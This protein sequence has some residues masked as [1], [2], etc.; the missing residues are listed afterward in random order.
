[1]VIQFFIRRDPDKENLPYLEMRFLDKDH[2]IHSPAVVFRSITEVDANFFKTLPDET[3]IQFID[4]D[5]T[6]VYHLPLDMTR[7][8]IRTLASFKK[9]DERVCFDFAYSLEHGVYEERKPARATR[10]PDKEDPRY[11]CNE[12]TLSPGSIVALYGHH[13]GGPGH[14]AVYIGGGYYLNPYNPSKMTITPRSYF[15]T[16]FKGCFVARDRQR[17]IDV[18]ESLIDAASED[19][20]YQQQLLMAAAISF[21][22][23]TVPLS[24]FTGKSLLRFGQFFYPERRTFPQP[25]LNA[26][27]SPD[28][29]K[30]GAKVGAGEFFYLVTEEGQL[31]L[32]KKRS[33]VTLAEI[34]GGRSLVSA[35]EVTIEQGR[36]RNLLVSPELNFSNEEKSRRVAQHVFKRF[37]VDERNFFDHPLV[38]KSRQGAYL[39]SKAVAVLSFADMLGFSSNTFPISLSTLGATALACMYSPLLATGFAFSLVNN[40]AQ[41]LK[42]ASDEDLVSHYAV[43]PTQD[44]AEAPRFTM[45]WM[46]DKERQQAS[47]VFAEVLSAVTEPILEAWTWF[48]ETGD[49]LLGELLSHSTAWASPLEQ[50]KESRCVLATEP[51][52]SQTFQKLIEGNYRHPLA[53]LSDATQAFRKVIVS[54]GQKTHELDPGVRD[55]FLQFYRRLYGELASLPLLQQ[56]DSA[57]IRRIIACAN[58]LSGITPQT[59]GSIETIRC[60]RDLGT[61]TQYVNSLLQPYIPRNRSDRTNPFVWQ[62][63]HLPTGGMTQDFPVP[64]AIEVPPLPSMIS[65]AYSSSSVSALKQFAEHA[66]AHHEPPLRLSCEVSASGLTVQATGRGEHVA[67]RLSPESFVVSV[68]CTG[69][70]GT[71]AAGKYAPVVAP[72]P[73]PPVT[74]PAAVVGA[75]GAGIGSYAGPVGA[76]VGGAIGTLFGLAFGGGRPERKVCPPAPAEAE[77]KAYHVP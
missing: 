3:E 49:R 30:K 63:A 54:L 39:A 13:E 52:L 20:R 43:I 40:L 61:T 77:P 32:V 1:M 6:R 42:H 31:S 15:D 73:A 29:I 16:N 76:L 57:E 35:G 36:V 37:G 10:F 7:N 47:K 62:S 69:A 66:Q 60:A 70:T 26:F 38:K 46:T 64:A 4:P 50:L 21:A 33:S 25:P 67:L 68:Q 75:V 14:I 18:L 8:L 9:N 65:P 23:P 28:V 44:K 48:K 59:L 22:I 45:D 24:Y 11:A 2:G 53:F 27:L 58:Y 74:E 72:P 12:S 34:V 5:G 51:M 71:S 41:F 19:I 17:D 55:V 56:L